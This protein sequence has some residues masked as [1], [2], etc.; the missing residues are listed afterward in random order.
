[1]EVLRL[2]PL[3]H[4]AK[5]LPSYQS[6]ARPPVGS[7]V[8]GRRE[9]EKSSL[10]AGKACCEYGEPRDSGGTAYPGCMATQGE[11]L[12]A[13]RRVSGES[14]AL[15]WVGVGGECPAWQCSALASCGDAVLER[16]EALGI[17]EHG[18]RSGLAAAA[19]QGAHGADAVKRRRRQ[20]DDGPGRLV[21]I[22]VG[23]EGMRWAGTHNGGRPQ[24]DAGQFW[25]NDQQAQQSRPRLCRL[26]VFMFDEICSLHTRRDVQRRQMLW[27]LRLQHTVAEW[28]PWVAPDNSGEGS[29]AVEDLVL[30]ICRWRS[31]DQTALQSRDYNGT[32]HCST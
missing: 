32:A 8:G 12:R 13:Q 20:G 30:R 1:M 9:I 26:W 24:R 10:E 31:Q 4:P 25:C 28:T 23:M 19:S 2:A 21:Q 3:G 5:A 15:I 18:A 6:W 7:D 17:L 16:S 27:V 11:V 22:G 29:M 14:A